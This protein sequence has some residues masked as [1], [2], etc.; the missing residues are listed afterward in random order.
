MLPQNYDPRATERAIDDQIFPYISRK[1]Y[2]IAELTAAFAAQYPYRKVLISNGT[3][4]RF[5]AISNGSA[6]Y[7]PDGTAV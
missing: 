7:Y 1:V 3:S 4:N 2:V 5:E 6:F